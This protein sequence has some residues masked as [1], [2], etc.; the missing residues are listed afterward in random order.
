MGRKGGLLGLFVL[1]G[2]IV[3]AVPSIVADSSQSTVGAGPVSDVQVVD[4][5][6]TNGSLRVRVVN[7][8]SRLHPLTDSDA[9]G[10]NGLASL[11]DHEQGRNI[12]NMAGFNYESCRTDPKA[13]KRIGL[14][15]APRVAP[16]AIVRVDS[17]TARLSQMGL[18]AAGLN[19]EITF[20]LGEGYVD[21][22]V[23][24][25]PDLDIK[26][27]TTFWASYMNLVQNT[28]LYLHAT[29]KRRGKHEWLEMTSAGHNGSG[30]GTYFRPFDPDGKRWD[31]FLVD[32]PVSRQA[33][34]ETPASR[35]ATEAAG[36]KLGQ[37][38]SFDNFFF[39]FVDD[40]VAL[41]IFRPVYYGNFN[42]WIS[43]SGA[44]AVRRPAWDFGIESGPQ[45]A[46]ERRTYHIRF[47]YKRYAGLEDLLEQVRQFQVSDTACTTT[48]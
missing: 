39:G 30:S 46:G 17:H 24:E 40:Y 43:A 27:S 22:T 34:F 9:A 31:Q 36:F 47:I 20:N 23:T 35:A 13:G 16:M 32:N 45:K 3:A 18:D 5:V 26:S 8:A 1:F 7:N 33:V 44:E 42:P 11:I 19:V 12:F 37:M 48:K 21:Q 15:N 41:W 6:L 2:T 28:S 29:L 4:A 14:W 38:A 25:W 10:Y